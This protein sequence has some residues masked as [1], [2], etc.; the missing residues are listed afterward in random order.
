[1]KSKT[2][3]DRRRFLELLSVAGVAVYLP[4]CGP[5][6][7]NPPTNPPASTK[8]VLVLG[9]GLAGL[10]AAY[11]L[12]KKGW[13]VTVL[14]AQTRVGG[15]VHTQHEGFENGQ[16]AELGATRIPDVH[17]HTIGYVEELGLK[18]EEFP[19]GTPLYYLG[20]NRFVH[21]EGTPW[22]IPGLSPEEA[23][24]G[25]GMWSTYIA[26]NFAE[27]GNPRDGS[28]PL[29]GIVEK[30]DG[31]VWT[32]YLKSKGATDA[33]LP[34]YASDNGTEIYK[35]GVLAWMA[36][37]T[38]DQDWSLTYHVQGGNDLI[39]QKL[40]EKLDGKVFFER[41]VKSIT[42]DETK[43]TVTVDAK[44]T[45]ETY[46]ADYLVCTIPLKP[47]RDV[48]FSPA[49]PDD[50]QKAMDEV[51]MMTS[52]RAMFQTKTRF[53][54]NDPLGELGGLKLAK[55]DTKAERVWDLTATQTGDTGILL[56]YLQDKN[57][58]DFAAI[59][60]PERE[61][62]IQAEL[63]KFFPD[64]EAEKLSF[65]MKVWAED[66]WAQGAWT[67]ILPNQWWMLAVLP[68]P[69][70]RIH[71]AGEHTSI[72]AGWMQGAIESAKRAVDEIVKKS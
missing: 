17:D 22:P 68:R 39:A 36:L 7:G 14:E 62:Y 45:S 19:D 46:E 15:R 70:G 16:Y 8:K 52:S 53:W 13:D 33:W 48:A 69:E 44:G 47:L 18:L 50:K 51:H 63:A 10:S 1:M 3:F 57:A 9:G 60:A 29:P 32:D 59:A 43:V 26:A 6:D 30:Y 24:E 41:V 64:I 12:M 65:H 72:W 2:R 4:G 71:F 23:T 42:Q 31:M 38:A 66:P 5:D 37:E 28:F 34:L 49:L 25:L 20:G 67:E 11:E 40:A 27:F 35:I 54:K 56:A 61:A 21:T 55:T 58:D